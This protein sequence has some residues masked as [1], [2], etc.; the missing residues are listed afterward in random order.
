MKCCLLAKKFDLAVGEY[1]FYGF[2]TFACDDHYSSVQSILS[3]PLLSKDGK[4]KI[5]CYKNYS[6]ACCFVRT[7]KASYNRAIWRLSVTKRVNFS[8]RM[9]NM[10]RNFRSWILHHTLLALSMKVRCCSKDR[11]ND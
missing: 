4:V 5:V 6:L 1:E 8:R 7:H 9:G 11:S 10:M 2:G 3:S